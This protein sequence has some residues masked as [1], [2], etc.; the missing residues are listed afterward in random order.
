MENFLSTWSPRVLSVLRFV[1]AFLFMQHGTQKMF[2]FPAPQRQ[3][4]D[5]LSMGGVAGAL[6]VFGG[7]LL[8]VGLFTRPTAFILS[9]LMAFAYFIAHAPQNFWPLLNGGE[10]AALWSFLFLYLAFAGG[11]EWSIDHWRRN[12]I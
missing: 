12:R 10:L 5:I 11:G 4:F 6:E 1:S 2:G 9:G 7:I 3:E 8:L